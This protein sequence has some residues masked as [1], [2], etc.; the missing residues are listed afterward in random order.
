M[1]VTR[2]KVRGGYAYR[3]RLMA[4]GERRSYGLY[5]TLEEAEAALAAALEQRGATSSETT[6]RAWGE[7]WLSDRE[8]QKVVRWTKKERSCWDAHVLPGKLAEMPLT[9]IRLK[10]VAA[11]LEELAKKEPRRSR[12]TLVHARR[13]VIG[14]L[15]AAMVHGLIDSNPAIGAPIAVR[16]ESKEERWTWLTQP[17][18]DAIL[19]IP[20][21]DPPSARGANGARKQGTI[22][23]AQHS[24]LTVAIFAG[25]RAG[26]LWGLRWKDVI[27]EGERRELIIRHSRE[28]ATKSG[29]VRR[30]PLLAP[31]AEALAQ[32]KA[33]APGVG[34]ALVWPAADGQCH[35]EGY[36]AGWARV[37]EL[38]GITRRVRWHDLRHTCASH[39]VQG[40]W[41]RTWSLMEVRDYLG[42]TSIKVTERYAHLCGGGLHA[43]AQLTAQQLPN[44]PKLNEKPV[45]L[46]PRNRS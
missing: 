33:L 31:A 39:L 24:A 37:K 11:W 43:A 36:D 18:I 16:R 10:H 25:L 4:E 35:R 29:T 12:Q 45:P 41:G 22:T 28:D 26:E 40:T 9:R 38:A 5:G 19:S 6:L 8:R 44:V 23:N 1:P 42:H 3:A 2:E 20:T 46:K 15:K 7:R 30:V 17:E 32:W 13:L 14:A 27:L 21:H 34:G